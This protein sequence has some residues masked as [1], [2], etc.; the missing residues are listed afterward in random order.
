MV[1]RLSR[2][3]FL[4]K[5]LAAAGSVAA[6]AVYTKEIEPRWLDV[7]RLTLSLPNLPPAFEG[8]TIVQVSDPHIDSWMPCA[9]L[10]HIVGVV[11]GTDADLVVVTGDFMTDTPFTSRPRA[12]LVEEFSRLRG[13]IAILGNHDYGSPDIARAIE[14]SGLVL[15]RNAHHAI[16]RGGDTLYIAGTESWLLG[17][18]DLNA[19]LGGIPASAPV[20]LLAHEPDFA[21]EVAATGRVEAQLS[22]HTHGGQVTLPF[23]GSLALREK[24]R[25]GY[26]RVGDMHLYVNVGVGTTGLRLRLFCRPEITLY[27][28]A[29]G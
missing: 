29:T 4:K 20:I 2:R 17:R 3:S 21:D 24:Y 5:S 15:L 16:T 1:R 22:G 8:Y 23:V 27:T 25:R 9:H 26:Y 12:T 18:D 11:L 10:R 13:G 7:N 14:E 6:S 28:L 19:A